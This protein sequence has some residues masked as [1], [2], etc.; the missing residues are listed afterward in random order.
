VNVYNEGGKPKTE[1]KW[2]SQTFE[3][4][5]WKK[6]ETSYSAGSSYFI[7]TN[8]CKVFRSKCCVVN[9]MYVNVLKMSLS[10]ICHL[11]CS[12]RN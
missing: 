12:E 10:C 11:L 8:S 9:M 7:V 6:T 1:P 3:G 2:R 4:G 5:T